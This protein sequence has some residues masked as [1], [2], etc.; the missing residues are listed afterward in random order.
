MQPSHLDMDARVNVDFL[1]SR[2]QNEQIVLGSVESAVTNVMPPCHFR[3]SFSPR[4][5]TDPRLRV[6]P[7]L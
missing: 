2:I 7:S 3:K 4:K 6:S 1:L 5:F